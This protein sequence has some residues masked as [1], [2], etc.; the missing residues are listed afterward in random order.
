MLTT[1]TP[2]TAEKSAE[3][4]AG[5]GAGAEEEPGAEALKALL[6]FQ[7]K[8][9]SEKTAQVRVFSFKMGDCDHTFIAGHGS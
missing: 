2:V 9:E 5:V 3:S 6:E 1:A 7:K 8:I 4:S